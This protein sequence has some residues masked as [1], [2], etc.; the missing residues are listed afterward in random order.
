MTSDFCFPI[1]NTNIE[2]VSTPFFIKN[3]PSFEGYVYDFRRNYNKSNH[4]WFQLLK[5]VEIQNEKIV[6]PIVEIFYD[7]PFSSTDDKTWLS[8]TFFNLK[9]SS[10]E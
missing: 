6:F 10:F 4:G 2:S 9:D 1:K 5:K 7:S 8:Q 3:F